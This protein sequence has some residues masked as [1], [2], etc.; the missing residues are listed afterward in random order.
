MLGVP[1]VITGRRKRSRVR[2]RNKEVEQRG[3]KRGWGASLVV[4]WIRIRLP[5][6]GTQVRSLAWEDSMCCRATKPGC[7]RAHKPQLLSP[8]TTVAEARAPRAWAL[9]QQ[10]SPQREAHSEEEPRPPQ[11][12]KARAQQGR[13]RAAK[14]KQI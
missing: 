3:L 7:S 12:E 2:G 13:S 1:A 9:R 5:M 14:N 10:K 11:L 4:Q 6:Q 8:H